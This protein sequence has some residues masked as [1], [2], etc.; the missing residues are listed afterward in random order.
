[1]HLANHLKLAV[2]FGPSM[3]LQRNTPLQVRGKAPAGATV[4][5]S[6]SSSVSRTIASDTGDFVAA[7]PPL[8]PGGPHTL[9]VTAG[10]A[11]IVLDDVLIGD[12]WLCSGQSN[13]EWTVRDSDHPAREL[14]DIDLP[15]VRLLNVPRRAERSPVSDFGGEWTRVSRASVEAFSAVGFYFARQLHR[16]TGVPIGIV[17]ACWGG[18]AAEAW[19]PIEGLGS[20]ESLLRLARDAQLDPDISPIGPH[21][22]RGNVG[23]AGGWA[24]TA[25]PGDWSPM[26][27]PTTWQRAGLAQNGAVW[28]RRT[29]DLAPGQAG[30]AATL[31]LGVA[32]DFDDT[33]VN[34]VRVGGMGT[35]SVNPWSTPRVYDIPPDLL[36]PG[37]NTIAV[38]VFDQW[39]EGGLS[40][41]AEAMYLATAAGQRFPLAGPWSYR[42]ERE[43][44]LRDP[45]GMGV[46]PATLYNG[47]IHPLTALPIAGALWYQGEAN[48]GRAEEY[49]ALLPAL[50]RSW[51]NAWS[52][53]FPFYIVQLAG[54]GDS[55]AH[56]TTSPWAD[57]RLAQHHA[58]LTTPHTHLVTAVDLG[59]PADIH[60]RNKQAVASRLVA[61]A[62]ATHYGVDRPWRSPSVRRVSFHAPGTAKVELQDAPG[63]ELR[64]A[65]LSGF[66]LRNADGEWF[67]AAARLVGEASLEVSANF[68]SA[69]TAVRYAW[70]DCP[71]STVYNSASL[72]LLAFIFSVV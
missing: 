57:L 45:N 4:V 48:V 36:R 1:M 60:P 41:P 70:Q 50:I 23:E 20:A 34:G 26:T 66:D 71:P 59:D 68:P 2:G 3:V 18:T 33:Y 32:D 31:G 11:R 38:R 17:S 52:T 63:L 10:G 16:E 49:R 40:G 43:L 9:D 42:V 27:L 61:A 15:L 24:E 39:G 14:A 7:L 65:A 44:P 53:E 72:P 22:D 12:V 13:M 51:R 58:A 67:P 35:D 28:F 37:A 19:T 29:L 6:I 30:G 62:L 54:F 5:V 55:P 8:P 47:M 69:P 21:V 64:P 46:L 56:P 25:A